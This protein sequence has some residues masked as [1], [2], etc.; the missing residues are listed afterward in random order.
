[1]D[2]VGVWLCRW[3]TDRVRARNRDPARRKPSVPQVQPGLLRLAPENEEARASAARK[4]RVSLSETR[5]GNIKSISDRGR[6][7]RL[8]ARRRA[9]L[10]VLR[11][12][13]AEELLLAQKGRPIPDHARH[14]SRARYDDAL[15]AAGLAGTVVLPGSPAASRLFRERPADR[16]RG[17]HAA[18]PC[19][20]RSRR[21]RPP[22]SPRYRTA[23]SSACS[24]TPF[25]GP[26]GQR[27]LRP[28]V[29]LFSSATGIARSAAA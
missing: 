28:W 22:V 2:A 20:S 17:L 13:Q 19:D 5:L 24:S 7:A 4:D 25:R 3:R 12:V 14:Q 15:L 16:Q 23:A 11:R 1:M 8:A 18:P 26:G 9:R 27:S 21:W 29:R 6:R 10:R